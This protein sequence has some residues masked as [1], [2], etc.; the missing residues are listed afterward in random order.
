MD[1]AKLARQYVYPAVFTPPRGEGE[2]WSVRFPD[3]AK[4]EKV[5]AKTLEVATLCAH[6][7][8]KAYIHS[9]EQHKH[10]AYLPAPCESVTVDE[11]EILQY[12]VV[13][14]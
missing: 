11:G 3:L 10:T 4:N 8:L 9:A 6:D 12:V 7:I 1:I 13:S 14:L 2:R 5:K